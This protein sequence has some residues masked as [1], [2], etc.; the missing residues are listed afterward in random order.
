MMMTTG[1]AATSISKTSNIVVN[2][3]DGDQLDDL[4]RRAQ[5]ERLERA[6]REKAQREQAK[7]KLENEHLKREARQT[8]QRAQTKRELEQRYADQQPREAQ[9]RGSGQRKVA[10]LSTSGSRQPGGGDAQLGRRQGGCS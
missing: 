6:A 4:Q 1:T 5:D 9:A 8:E 7:L 10:G 3:G 2:R